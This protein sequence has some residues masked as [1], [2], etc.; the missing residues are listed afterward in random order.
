[1]K[2]GGTTA[3]TASH[4]TGQWQTISFNGAVRHHVAQQDRTAL[5]PT[6]RTSG[7][8]RNLFVDY[9]EVNGSRIEAETATYF[10][11]GMTTI[12]GTQSMNWVGS[13]IFNGPISPSRPGHHRGQA[14]RPCSQGSRP[15]RRR[16]AGE[17]VSLQFENVT[18]KAQAAGEITFGHVFKQ[19]DLSHGKYLVAVIDGREVP[20]QLDVKA[21]NEDGSVRHAL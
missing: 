3:V 18:G 15:S 10:R 6:I 20:V 14:P 11:P 17:I 5:P 13:L 12:T 19:G 2:V 4:A 1:M 8:D 21:T 7:G 16:Q 9:I